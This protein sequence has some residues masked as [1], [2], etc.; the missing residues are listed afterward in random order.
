MK[1]LISVIFLFVTLLLITSCD[2]F[3]KNEYTGKTF[4]VRTELMK[5][6]ETEVITWENANNLTYDKEQYIYK[7]Y[8]N[9]KLISL[10]PKGTVIIEEQ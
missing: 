9:G 1:N 6:K 10:E 8:V 2:Y 7:F 5:G 3:G 4:K